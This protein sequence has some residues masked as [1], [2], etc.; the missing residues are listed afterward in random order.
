MSA[1][2]FPQPRL[3]SIRAAAA[4][5]GVSRTTAWKLAS[6]GTLESLNLGGLRMIRAESLHHLIAEGTPSAKKRPDGVVRVQ[7]R[8]AKVD[9]DR[10]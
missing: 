9:R 6:D 7:A 4:A 8:D 3:Y 1:K 10:R 5:L 2:D